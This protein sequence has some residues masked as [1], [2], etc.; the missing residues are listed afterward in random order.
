MP[1]LNTILYGP[2]GTGKTYLTSQ[3]AIQI[4]ENLTDTELESK[5]APDQRRRLKT[6]F[7]E[8]Q[9]QGKVALLTF[10]PSFAYE[11]FVE[12]IK[13]FKN[14]KND[15]YYDVEDGIFKQICFNAAY[16]LYLAQQQ[17]AL[18]S[19]A[20]KSENKD[21]AIPTRPFDAL[22]FEFIDYLKRMMQEGSEEITFETKQGKGVN[23]VNINQNN[24]L[25][26]QTS[27]STKHYLVTK[28]S[29]AKLYRA[30]SSIEEIQNLAK[31]I[32]SV[33]GRSNTSVMWAAFHR[34]KTFE[35]TR[36]RTY[37]SLLNNHRL[38]GNSVSKVQ[39][40][41]MK[42]A[43]QQLDYSTLSPND[44]Q[45][46][47][48]FV[49]IIDEINRGNPASIFGE[50]ISL[51]ED[52]KRA[53]KEEALQT[54]LPYSREPFQV[55]PNLYIIGTMNTAD[56][57]VDTLDLAFRRRFTFQAVRPQPSLL[58]PSISVSIPKNESNKSEKLSQAAEPKVSYTRQKIHLD[59]LLQ[60]LNERLLWLKGE[61]YQF[62]HAYF[63][64]V[65]NASDALLELRKAV[66]QQVIPLLEEYFFDDWEKRIRVIGTAFVEEL[67]GANLLQEE[68]SLYALPE[69]RYR[70][71]QLSD[72]EFLEAV[73]RIYQHA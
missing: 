65:F 4:I 1:S 42:R 48:N 73:H 58:T 13:P 70:W 56:Q 71:R 59:K 47:G 68:A 69:K 50:L 15:L 9:Q 7:N 40:Q 16:A 32:G 20:K 57:S 2:P 52:D 54:V 11:D 6:R 18:D 43:I 41:Q 33:V 53:G 34:L 31:D 55:P 44:F 62:G 22:F 29:L 3:R 39:Y 37:N 49:L 10:H 61:E 60:A 46:A 24:T 12:G 64:P 38:S 25:A 26:F 66:Y 36:Y 51:I 72:N 17:R 5:Y 45:Q 8:Y 63:L 35:A 14:E 30:F 28:N 19:L 67:T 21:K 23:L 27:R